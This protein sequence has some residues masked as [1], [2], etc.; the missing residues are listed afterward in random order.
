MSAIFIWILAS[1]LHFL[2]SWWERSR[3]CDPEWALM[4]FFFLWSSPT[5]HF[6]TE[7]Q[8]DQLPFYYET[9]ENLSWG[10]GEEFI[11]EDAYLLHP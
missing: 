11:N 4:E 1:F 3:L 2:N 7:H 9:S 10:R 8:K 5:D 6:L